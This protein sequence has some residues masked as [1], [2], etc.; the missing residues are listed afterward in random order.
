MRVQVL[1]VDATADGRASVAAGRLAAGTYEFRVLATPETPECLGVP[2]RV[3]EVSST[4][5]IV[6]PTPL[7][8]AILI[9]L[10]AEESVFQTLLI[11][12]KRVLD[13][14]CR[15]R[16]CSRHSIKCQTLSRL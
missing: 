1:D 4:V 2:C 8:H 11:G 10:K 9:Q 13:T 5:V 6:E 12:T 3:V 14:L 16:K 7:T 15:V